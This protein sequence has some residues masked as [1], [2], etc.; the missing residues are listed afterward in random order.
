MTELDQADKEALEMGCSCPICEK[1]RRSLKEIYLEPFQGA[2]IE[3][4]EKQILKQ[5]IREEH[6]PEPNTTEGRRD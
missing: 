3:D 6:P 5:Y 4:W 2:L 1:H